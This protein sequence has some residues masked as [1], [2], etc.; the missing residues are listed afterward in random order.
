MRKGASEARQKVMRGLILGSE[1][2]EKILTGKKTWEIRGHATT[3]RGEVVL[4]ASKTGTAVGTVEIVDVRGP[5]TLRELKANAWKAG[6][7]AAMIPALPYPKTFAWVLARPRR[8]RRS[9]PY[10]HPQGAVIWV[11]LSSYFAQRVATGG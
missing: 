11:R 7:A 6:L 3:V 1:W 4:L 2:V 8:L 9:V 10:R 5:L